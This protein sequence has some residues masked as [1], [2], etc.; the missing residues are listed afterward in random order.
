[1]ILSY[2][3]KGDSA[4]TKYVLLE[5]IEREISV[6]EFFDTYEA[7]YTKMKDYVLEA[8]GVS[9]LD[10]ASDFDID[11]NEAWGER[12]GQNFD[13]KIFEVKI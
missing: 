5:V 11:N 12:Y 2:S 9:E 1:M 8:A 4:M 10:D 7:A 6:P 3:I 13:W